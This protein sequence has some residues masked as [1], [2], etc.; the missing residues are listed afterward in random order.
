MIFSRNEGLGIWGFLGQG[1][2]P[3]E[4]R[5]CFA[6][7]NH[8]CFLDALRSFNA[9]SICASRGWRSNIVLI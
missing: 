4:G 9:A 3:L 8:F 5:V 6:L 2:Q 1:G 7:D